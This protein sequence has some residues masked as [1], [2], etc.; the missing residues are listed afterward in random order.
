MT[1]KVEQLPNI[2]SLDD[3]HLG[4]YLDIDSDCGCADNGP[5]CSNVIEVFNDGFKVSYDDG[6]HKYL[7]SM[8]D[9]VGTTRSKFGN[10][11]HHFSK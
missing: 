2:T 11:V 3:I 1:Q 8:K 9:Y 10:V 6:C 5:W 4:D 7:P